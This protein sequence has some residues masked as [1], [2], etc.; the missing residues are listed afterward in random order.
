MNFK[1]KGITVMT[2]IT[3]WVGRR[4]KLSTWEEFG[5]KSL[6]KTPVKIKNSN[7]ITY[8]NL[9]VSTGLTKAALFEPKK[10]GQN[11]LVIFVHD[12][13]HD[14][15][16][17]FWKWIRLFTESG[18]SVLCFDFDGHGISSKSEL[19]LQ[20]ATRTLPLI[21]QR[22]YGESQ[23][24][25]TFQKKASFEPKCYL[26]GYALGG[27]YSLIAGSHDYL[28]NVLNGIVSIC[29]ILSKTYYHDYLFSKKHAF[30]KPLSYFKLRKH[31]SHLS[32]FKT[33]ELASQSRRLP[34]RLSISVNHM[35][36]LYQF[37]NEVIEERKILNFIKVPTLYIN[38]SEI[39]K[40]MHSK[41]IS[42]LQNFP[43]SLFVYQ[44]RHKN[45]I[46]ILNDELI[47]QYCKD[48]ISYSQ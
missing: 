43:S 25:K 7:T 17:L 14:A 30:T 35:N 33:Q 1:G 19:D 40:E 44:N 24:T 45:L 47:I 13:G 3:E 37:I 39:S 31:Y 16:Y 5:H 22:L 20:E 6:R 4:F 38:N 32:Q 18:L 36:Q 42:F 23:N 26:L 48:F 15:T 28:S 8:Y 2:L 27:I 12:F 21:I 11:T 9:I 29:P 10:N 46:E 41:S 34:V